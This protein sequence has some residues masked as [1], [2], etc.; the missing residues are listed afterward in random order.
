MINLLNVSSACLQG[1]CITNIFPSKS[2]S[3]GLKT[4]S[5]LKWKGMVTSFHSFQGLS[6]SFR[7]LKYLYNLIT[8]NKSPLSFY[9]RLLS[10]CLSCSQ[11]L[12]EIKEPFEALLDI[13]KSKDVTVSFLNVTMWWQSV[14]LT[15]SRILLSL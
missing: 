1:L 14:S 4:I 13:L 7:L 2:D 3:W 8:S 6:Q 5:L 11:E 9:F 12:E 15:A 10:T